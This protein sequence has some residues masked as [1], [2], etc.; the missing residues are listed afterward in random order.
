[1]K[2]IKDWFKRVFSLLF[3]ASFLGFVVGAITNMCLVLGIYALGKLMSADISQSIMIGSL[4]A[5]P[6]AKIANK[7]AYFGFKKLLK[8]T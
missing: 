3:L 7:Y 1:M 6:L 4:F 5:Y 8:I 2:K